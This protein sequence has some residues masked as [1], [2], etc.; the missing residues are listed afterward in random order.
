M[1]N[2]LI[3]GNR[4][5]IFKPFKE[6]EKINTEEYY[7]VFGTKENVEI[8]RSITIISSAFIGMLTVQLKTE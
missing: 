3:S 4:K 2:S 5:V 7:Y 8:L 6:I 1:F